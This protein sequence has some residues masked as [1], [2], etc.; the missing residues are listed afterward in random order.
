MEL[1]VVPRTDPVGIERK[2][3][4]LPGRCSDADMD[5]MLCISN[6]AVDDMELDGSPPRDAI[7]SSEDEDARVTP[8]LP[9]QEP[10]PRR[11]NYD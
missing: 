1:L 4:V 10:T 5:F 3:G 8:T 6:D 9:I 11:I 7:S 2:L